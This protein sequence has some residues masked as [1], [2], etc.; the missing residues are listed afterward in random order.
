MTS[1]NEALAPAWSIRLA[2][3]LSANDQTAH[4]LADGLT[5]EQLNWH[6]APNS[7]S[8]GQC[9]EHI[10]ITNEAYLTSMSA[11]LKG[12]SDSPVEQI[13][14][15]FFS[16]WF[17]RNFVEPSPNTKRASAPSKIRPGARVSLAVL[18]RFLSDNK[19]CRELIVRARSKDINRIRFWNPLAPGIRFT[20]GT[21]LEI[22]SSHERRH[23]LQ[24]ERVRDSVNFP[25]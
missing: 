1:P 3:E 8:V 5:E 14:P 25:R 20:V 7:W 17:I 9:L 19:S 18:D 24:A 16:R 23:L 22:I 21:G 15:G 10:C 12:R 6:N 2:F 13:T 4:A 11:V